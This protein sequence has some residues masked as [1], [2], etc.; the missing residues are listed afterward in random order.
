MLLVL[1]AIG[2]RA[3]SCPHKTQPRTTGPMRRDI[4]RDYADL[5][6]TRCYSLTDIPVGLPSH[7]GRVSNWSRP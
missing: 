7:T 5:S 3:D 1:S 4:A 6:L 2:F